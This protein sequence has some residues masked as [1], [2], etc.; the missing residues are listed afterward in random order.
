MLPQRLLK[1]GI[2]GSLAGCGCREFFVKRHNILVT[3]A[4]WAA[5]LVR[6]MFVSSFLPQLQLSQFAFKFWKMGQ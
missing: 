1:L 6:W 4:I 3:Q 2:N 5:F